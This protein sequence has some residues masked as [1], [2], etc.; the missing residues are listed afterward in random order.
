MA[1]ELDGSR[2]DFGKSSATVRTITAKTLRYYGGAH[3]N[4]N[5]RSGKKDGGQADEM[6][7]ILEISHSEPQKKWRE[8]ERAKCNERSTL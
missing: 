3:G 1:R 5:N 6:G 2:T 8:E 7:R 4:E